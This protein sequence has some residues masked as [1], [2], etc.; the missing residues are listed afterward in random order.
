MKRAKRA[1]DGLDD[2]IRDHIERETSDNLDRGMTPEEARRQ[3]M[4]KFGN[5]ALTKED[6]RAVW[7]RLWLERVREDLRVAARLLRGHPAFTAVT[8]T[9]LARGVGA[10]TAMFSIVH[11]VVLRPLPFR[12]SDRLVMLEEKWLPRFPRFEASPLSVRTSLGA[13]RGRIVQ[14]LLTETALLSLLGGALGLAVA[15]GAIELVRTWPWPGIHRLEE[16][17]LD[18]LRS[19]LQSRSRSARV[20]SAGS[21]PPFASPD[22]TCMMR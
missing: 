11:N 19:W 6:T 10:T 4:P 18:P 16:T 22:R 12:D 1:L 17:S 9:V 7:S 13:T 3:A 2:D 14:Q 15:L 5:M 21:L 8:L 20:C